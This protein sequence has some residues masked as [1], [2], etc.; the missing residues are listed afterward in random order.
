[1]E[2]ISNYSSQIEKKIKKIQKETKLNIRDTDIGNYFLSKKNVSEFY[3]SAFNKTFIP[4]NIIKSQNLIKKFK[5]VYEYRNNTNVISGYGLLNQFFTNEIQNSFFIIDENALNN[6]NNK[7]I[8]KNILSYPHKIFVEEIKAGKD[9]KSIISQVKNI[10]IDLII[11]VG[12]GRCADLAK[13]ISFKTKADCVFVV[14]SLATHVYASPKIHA[15]EPIKDYG[16]QLTIDGKTPDLSILDLELLMQVSQTNR[17]LILAGFG[18][19]M[20]FWTSEKDWIL[21]CKNKDKK[22]DPFVQDVIDDIF[23]IFDEISLEEKFS[24]WVRSY[25]L[26]QNQLCHITDWVGSAPASGS[27]HLFANQIEKY[28][29]DNL[30]LHGELVALGVVIFSSL[31]NSD[32]N[33]IID[34]LD[35]FN[36]PRSISKIGVTKDSIIEALMD[37]KSYGRFKNRYT[38]VEEISY[39]KNEWLILIDKLIDEKILFI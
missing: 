23:N 36:I 18:D 16:Y 9:L 12:G 26:I 15:L 4:S 37:S 17:R 33:K 1:M 24:N 35:K 14:T 3:I 25:V 30:P 7:E 6:I 8:V 27:E 32:I 38:I 31:M 39:K 22:I 29:K 34:L 19:L 28:H 5:L 2:N 20:A 13:F 10:K 21:S 11:G